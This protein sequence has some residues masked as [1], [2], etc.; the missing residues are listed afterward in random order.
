M[1]AYKKGRDGQESPEARY[2][3]EALLA[4]LRSRD[5]SVRQKARETLTSMGK[6]AV[7]QLIPLLKDPTDDV[8]WEAAKALADIGDARAASA[9]VTAL[10]DENTGVRWLAAVGLI[11]IGRDAL[12]PMLK[13]LI[14]R[15]DAVW[16]RDG[17]HHVLHDLAKADLEDL[18]TPIVAALEGSDPEIRLREPASHA[19][20]ALR[21]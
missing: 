18:L 6:R 11:V 2:H 21:R 3:P 14:E 15:A 9:L 12:V 5:G 17:A 10:E 4:G 19:L 16:L 8:R 13:A 7:R 1:T 20:Q